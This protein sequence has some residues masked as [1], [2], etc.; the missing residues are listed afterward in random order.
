M[1]V[2]KIAN[3]FAWV[4]LI[5]CYGCQ[6]P[7]PSEVPM[8]TDPLLVASGADMQRD[9]EAKLVEQMA[10]YRQKYID[11]LE[12]LLGFYENQ[13]N[14]LKSDWVRGELLHLKQGPQ[15]PYL[16]V[17]ETAGPNLHASKS[18]LEADLLYR[19]GINLMKEGRGGIGKIGMDE[20]KLYLA[21]DKFSD[22]ISKY[23]ESNLIG[24]AAFQIGQIYHQYLGDYAKALLYYQRVWQWDPQTKMPVRFY[25][26]RV[27]DDHYH[28]WPQAV[29]FYEQAISQES[30]YSD[31]VVYSQNRIR[32][33]NEELSQK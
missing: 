17:A 2:G 6:R 12:M 8:Q 25:T 16:V 29:K 22:L 9:E 15:H 32:K 10:Q 4:V 20:K 1:I 14:Q 3:G 24:D 11:Q 30:S 5:A 21:K 28:N 18:I 7:L 19:E 23:P 33:I 13:G 26:A 31:N 27:Y